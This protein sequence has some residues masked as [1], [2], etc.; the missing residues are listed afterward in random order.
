MNHLIQ[1]MQTSS[2]HDVII[3][4]SLIEASVKIGRNSSAEASVKPAE[5]FFADLS[6]SFLCHLESKRN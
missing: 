4:H 2:L 6:I 3:D 1:N 5:R